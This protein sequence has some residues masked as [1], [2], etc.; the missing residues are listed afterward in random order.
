MS[1]P[2]AIV[3]FDLDGTLLDTSQDLAAAAN[4]ALAAAG[5]DPL[6]VEAV[7]ARVGGGTRNMLAGVLEASGGAT[8]EDVDRLLPVLL[9]HYKANMTVHTRPYAGAAAALDA[10][11]ARGVTLAVVTNK[12]ERFAISLL[13]A[14]G[15]RD[16]FACVIGGDTLPVGKPAPDGILEMVR[17]CGGGAAAFIGD[18]IYDVE[19]ARAANVPVVACRFGFSPEAVDGLG[20]DAVIDGFDALIA[21]LE[22]L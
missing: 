5:R 9:A 12:L 2:F 7:L 8:D 15:L 22:R 10:L 21:A 6:P 14:T 19:A 11:A 13:E 16:R 3:G 17:R 20:A 18:S 1:F 4:A